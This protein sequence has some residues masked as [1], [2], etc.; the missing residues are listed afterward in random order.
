M[1]TAFASAIDR[2]NG[3]AEVDARWVKDHLA[4]IDFIDVREPHELFGP[5]GAAYGVR[6]VPLQSLLATLGQQD[7]AR[8]M[9][10]ICRSGRRSGLAVDAFEKAGF[11]NVASV[12]GGTL[13]WNSRV[14][15]RHDV[16]VIEKT[17]GAES[18]K[19]AQYFTNNMGV[20]EVS[21]DWVHQHVGLFRLV[22]VRGPG[23]LA[24]PGESVLQAVNVPLDTLVKASQGWDKTEPLVMMCRSGGRSAR[25]AQYLL[26]AGFTNVA[27]MEGG[28]MGWAAAGLP[29][30]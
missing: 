15:G 13:A 5:L 29:R 4:E 30:T 27:S 11:T 22:D 19:E 24:M 8:P 3:V 6:N 18:I 28:M 10:L 17:K 7:K 12:E 1:N 21:V 20:P 2:A 26:S 23:E 25:A 14:L 16:H 9:V